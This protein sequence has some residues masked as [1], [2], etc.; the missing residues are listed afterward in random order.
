MGRTCFLGLVGIPFLGFNPLFIWGPVFGL[1]QFG[2]PPHLLKF[3][4]I[5][6]PGGH[7]EDHQ[8]SPIVG[9]CVIFSPPLERNFNHACVAA[10]VVFPLRGGTS[11]KELSHSLVWCG[12][13][14][15]S[16]R[17]HHTRKVVAEGRVQC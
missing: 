3:G 10:G 6:T 11:E 15:L 5:Y 9:V 13:F 1:G 17:R 2:G 12:G 4:G 7:T 8:T 14:L 16:R